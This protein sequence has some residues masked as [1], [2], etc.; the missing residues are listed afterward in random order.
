MSRRER[1]TRAPTSSPRRSLFTSLK[2]MDEDAP[3][4]CF[5]SCS[6]ALDQS[7]LLIPSAMSMTHFPAISSRLEYPNACNRPVLTWRILPVSGSA[8][9]KHSEDASTSSGSTR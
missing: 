9:S 4:C 2:L 7:V 8:N 6:T 3:A 1:T 5:S